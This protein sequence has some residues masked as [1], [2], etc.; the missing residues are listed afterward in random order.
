[1]QAVDVTGRS[2]LRPVTDVEVFVDP[3]CPW[4]WVTAGWVLEAA[5]QRDLAAYRPYCL[6]IRD[7]YGVA[8]TV[9]EQDRQAAVEGHA[10]SHSMLRYLRG[11]AG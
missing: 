2:S 7:D 4:P 10:L 9:P 6:Q 1:M 11:G 8:A 5:P 3:S